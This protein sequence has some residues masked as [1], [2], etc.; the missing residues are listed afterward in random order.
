VT[1]IWCHLPSCSGI[2]IGCYRSPDWSWV[3]YELPR[4]KFTWF[5]K[6]YWVLG[7]KLASLPVQQPVYQTHMLLSEP[8]LMLSTLW[9]TQVDI[10]LFSKLTGL[11]T[12]W[13]PFLHQQP[14]YQH[15][16]LQEPRLKLGTLCITQ[17]DIHLIRNIDYWL[18]HWQ[19][20]GILPVLVSSLPNPS[21]ITGRS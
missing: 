9:I 18:G 20:T 15:M 8:R 3:H 11:W 10:H 12:T 2:Q 21:V 1:W 4:S 7:N 6:I 13:H 17:V 5:S 19:Q 14:V 16:L